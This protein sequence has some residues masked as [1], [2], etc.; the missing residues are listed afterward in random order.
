MIC[1]TV[2]PS[3][4]EGTKVPRE[5]VTCL[6]SPSQDVGVG[7]GEQTWSPGSRGSAPA[8]T[9]HHLCNE[10]LLF[11]PFFFLIEMN[12]HNIKLTLL[13]YANQGHLLHSPCCPTTASN[14]RMFSIIQRGNPVPISSHSLSLGH[15]ATTD[16]LSVSVDLPALDILY[17]WN[18]ITWPFAS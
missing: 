8:P 10:E 15:L 9:L 4:D 11:F 18:H 6:E 3:T 2:H 14:S 17:K 5:W 13:K 7:G 12:L 16:L 1:T